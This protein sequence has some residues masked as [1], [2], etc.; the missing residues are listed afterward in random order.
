MISR[1]ASDVTWNGGN[2]LCVSFPLVFGALL[3][4]LA[5]GETWLLLKSPRSPINFT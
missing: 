2:A 1:T 3:L 5:A 4:L